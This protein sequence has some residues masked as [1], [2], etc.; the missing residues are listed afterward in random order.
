MA[1]NRTFV[2][3]DSSL[4]R[5]GFRILTD[6]LQIENFKQNPIMFWMHKRTNEFSEIS[7]GIYI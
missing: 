4:N 6:G 3:S 1:E 2:L 7:I 5:Y